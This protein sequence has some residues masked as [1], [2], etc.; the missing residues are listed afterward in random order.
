MGIEIFKTAS[1]YGSGASLL[2][3]YLSFYEYPWEALSGI[4]EAILRIGYALPPEEY[5]LV[6]EGVWIA[7][8][9]T[10]AKSAS[11]S[12]P[13]I[14]D[15][16]AEVRHCAFIRG[17][18]LVGKHAVVGNSTELKNAILFDYAAAPH[19]NYVGD[20]ILGYRAH[21][22]ASAITSNLKSDKSGV[23]IKSTGTTIETG[24]KKCGAFLGDFAEIGCGA[25]LNPGTVI[26]KRTSVYPLS[27][28]RGCVLPDS[29]YK[30][31]GIVV[32]RR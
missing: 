25:V 6:S 9:A 20:S 5:E 21:M 24:L 13:C 32:K 14:I 15:E 4:K 1:L 19:F 16:G 8:S 30:R 23:A 11:I 28:V 22:G 10:V 27:S 26:G 31:S 29:I 17:G 3:D 18:A 2:F 12:M 7:R